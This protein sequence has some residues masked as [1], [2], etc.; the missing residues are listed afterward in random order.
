LTALSGDR[1]CLGRLGAPYGIKGWLKLVSFTQPRDNL[2]QYRKFTVQVKGSDSVLE[3]DDARPHGKGLIGHFVGYDTPE[4]ARELT[5][6][7][8]YVRTESLPELDDGDYYWHQLTGLLV[9]NRSGVLLGQVRSLLETGAND[10]LV[11][12]ATQDSVDERQ[13]LIPWLPE[14]VVLNVDLASGKIL[15]DWEADYLM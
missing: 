4:H 2:L 7:E 8:L 6:I 11:V 10:V 15:V 3:M 5:G 1:I 13:R 14:Q 9:E 12:D